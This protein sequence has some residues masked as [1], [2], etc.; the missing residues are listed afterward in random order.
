MADDKPKEGKHASGTSK[1]PAP[2]Y[3]P[4][5]GGGAKPGTGK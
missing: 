1:D 4:R 3:E 5:H 2:G